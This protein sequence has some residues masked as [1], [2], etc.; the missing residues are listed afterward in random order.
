MLCSF[1]GS[2]CEECVDKVCHLRA[3]SEW[4][5]IVLA[6]IVFTVG[7]IALGRKRQPAIA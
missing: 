4:G 5:L 7:T 1:E 3:V 6:L 2:V